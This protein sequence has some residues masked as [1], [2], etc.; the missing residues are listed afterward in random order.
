MY[1]VTI[2]SYVTQKKNVIIIRNKNYLDFKRNL[3]LT[4]KLKTLIKLT[5]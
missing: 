4:N 1:V 2:A 5:Q 3:P